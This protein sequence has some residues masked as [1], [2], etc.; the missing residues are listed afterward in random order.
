M[1]LEKKKERIAKSGYIVLPCGA[2]KTLLGI[3]IC[4]KIKKE[5]LIVC[6]SDSGADQWKREI[7][8]W[9]QGLSHD[10]IVILT[11]KS[12]EDFKFSVKD[13]KGK[14]FISTY[15]NLKSK[16]ESREGEQKKDI[17]IEHEWMRLMPWGLI[18]FDEAQWLPAPGNSMIANSL[19]AHVKIGLTAT[20]LREDEEIKSLIYMIGP[21]LYV[22]SWRKFVELGYLAN[23][24]C[25]EV[26]TKLT[27]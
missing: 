14:I 25:I 21:Q 13:S 19:Q 23:P 5:T 10:Q 4:T 20:P 26:R 16:L 8:K 3:A 7:E 2:G 18:V 1:K 11:A 9:T 24:K 27:R 17:K 12:I 22:G 6:S 15:S